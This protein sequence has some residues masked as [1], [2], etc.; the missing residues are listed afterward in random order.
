[1]NEY[2]NIA[3]VVPDAPNIPGLTFRGFCGEAD[4]AAMASVINGSKDADEQ[5]WTLDAED[6]ARDYAHLV[7]SDPYRDMLFVEVYGEV[8]GYSRVWWEQELDGQR[9]YTHFCHLLPE[10]R[11]KGIRCAMLRHNERRALEIALS[12]QDGEH[13]SGGL[14]QAWASDKEH[15]WTSLLLGEGYEAVRY[16]FEMVRPNLDDVPDLPL[17]EGL[18]VRPVRPEHYRTIWEADEEAFRDHW[19]ATERQEQDF[20][21][22]QHSP[23]FTP[24]LWQVAWEG[25]QV[26]GMVR[27]FINAEENAEYGRLRGYTE[28]ISVRRPWRRRGLARALIARSLQLLKERGMTEAALGV[29]AENPNGALR[30]YQSMGFR[31]VKRS[32]TF[33]KPLL[34]RKTNDE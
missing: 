32:M 14:F 13:P 19:G 11:G 10:W 12:H 4:Y 27:S 22:W 25:E 33:R 28:F 34:G 21:A 20:E 2:A 9:L 29:D 15:D 16:G 6:V 23:Q 7:N 18:E 26:A 8:V 31:E 1:M 30:L 17:P 24:E 3:I 5:E